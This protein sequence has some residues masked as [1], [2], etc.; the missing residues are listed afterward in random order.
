[1]CLCRARVTVQ[2]MAHMCRTAL[3][4]LTTGSPPAAS[5]VLKA[6]ATRASIPPL[7]SAWHCC[8][9][10]NA[11]T[12]VATPAIMLPLRVPCTTG[13]Y[14]LL[15]HGQLVSFWTICDKLCA[16]KGRIEA[17]MSVR[18][19]Y[20]MNICT[21]RCNASNKRLS[22][23]LLRCSRRYTT[24]T[25]LDVRVNTLV[26][27][28]G[29]CDSSALHFEASRYACLSVWDIGSTRRCPAKPRLRSV[30]EPLRAMNIHSCK[31]GW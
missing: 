18:F 31:L 3:D 4:G 17:Y 14:C 8:A 9:G 15:L 12:A 21:M 7:G 13:A 19:L 30:Q 20:S 28:H 24:F 16:C 10:R 5:A 23:L 2:Q 6:L 26:W 29:R 22:C 27:L 1:M 25:R 11:S